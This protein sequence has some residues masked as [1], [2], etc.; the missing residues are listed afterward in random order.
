MLIT[1][2]DR[3]K[4][5]S[6]A[7]CRLSA[8]LLDQIGVCSS[9]RRDVLLIGGVDSTAARQ[10]HFHFANVRAHVGPNEAGSDK[11]KTDNLQSC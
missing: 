9:N 1:P 6:N 2:F 5:A 3:H 7:N 4:A 8:L 11:Q 10:F